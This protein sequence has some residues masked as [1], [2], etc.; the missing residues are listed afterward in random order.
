M[1]TPFF[2]G[3]VVVG[4][5]V[6]TGFPECFFLRLRCFLLGLFFI[7]RRAATFSLSA[8]GEVNS[9]KVGSAP[10]G[11]AIMDNG[12]VALED[13]DDDD[14]DDDVVGIGRM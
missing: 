10:S 13:D 9:I 5:A 11:R 8:V 12:V 3:S 2:P 6:V 1:A 14:D 4:E 7:R